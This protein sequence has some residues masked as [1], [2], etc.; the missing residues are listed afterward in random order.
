MSFKHKNSKL[1]YYLRSFSRQLLP[2]FFFQKKLLKKLNYKGTLTKEEL[3]KLNFRL[4]YY[5]K[6]EESYELPNTVKRISEISKKDGSKVY[7]FDFHEYLKYFKPNLKVTYLFGDITEIPKTPSFVKSRPISNK[8]TNSI[9]LKWNK[10]RH[11]IYVKNDKKKFTKKKN[12][13]VF[14]GRVRENLPNRVTFIDEFFD[15][16]LCDVGDVNVNG[17]YPHWKVNRMTISE[18]LEYKFILSL[19][20]NDVATNL[21]WIMSSNS[22]AVMPKPKFETWFME[23]TLIPNYHYILIKDDYSDLE[24][25]LNYYIE[26]PKKG[27]AIV[28]NANAYSNQFKNK[29]M[30]DL[31]SLMVIQKYFQKTNQQK[32]EHL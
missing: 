16:P 32:L 1:F 26:N 22:I 9:I 7:F 19:E 11:F 20:G 5:N 24:E 30:E 28:K 23:G 15:H 18:Q 17:P 14:R 4:N 29:K 31:L 8:N 21:K 12:Q 25:Q 2:S 6:L 13:L 27:E 10:V 3:N